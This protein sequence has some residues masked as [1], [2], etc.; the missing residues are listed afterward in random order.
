MGRARDTA[1]NIWETDAQGKAV[2]LITAAQGGGMQPPPL[3]QR[4]VQGDIAKQ[5]SDMRNDSERLKIDQARLRIA[6]QE[7]EA[8]RRNASAQADLHE[9]EL[10]AKRREMEAQNPFNPMT[11]QSLQDDAMQKL[12]VIDRISENYNNSTLPAVGFGSGMASGIPGSGAAQLRVNMGELSNAGALQRIKELT[13]QNGGKNPLTPMSRSD[14]DLV[15]SSVSGVDPNQQGPVEFFRSIEPYKR[16]YI[17]AYAGASG[18][19][20]LGNVIEQEV[21]KWKSENPGHTMRQERAFRDVMTRQAKANYER[22]MADIAAARSRRSGTGNA[23]RKDAELDALMSK[24][25]GR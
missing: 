13:A 12:G 7:A 25:G 15:S 14:V 18:M 10:E 22:R 9:Y 3:R 19:R 21:A 6:E 4:Q 23:P 5:A 16:S 11:L 2:R 24:Y 1:G 8:N 20:A 17:N